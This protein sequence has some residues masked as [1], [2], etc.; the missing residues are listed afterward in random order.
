MSDFGV[1]NGKHSS[2]WRG[3]EDSEKYML[4]HSAS[5]GCLSCVKKF[6]LGKKIS[7]FSE[8]DH[9]KDNAFD[10]CEYGLEQGD[11][12]SIEAGAVMEFLN[13]HSKVESETFQG[14]IEAE[15]DQARIEPEMLC[16]ACEGSHARK[17]A[18][19]RGPEY[20]YFYAA[21]DGCVP[22]V[23]RI[24]SE[25]KI[26]V[27]S[28]SLTCGYDAIEWAVYGRDHGCGRRG[29]DH[30]AVLELVQEAMGSDGYIFA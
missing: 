18:L 27:F 26:D 19:M 8:S 25:G 4:F 24:V 6:V 12:S 13:E 1:C 29:K 30:G 21:R 28:K 16:V 17:Q 10:W 9:R 22:C 2:P 14:K 7:V 3:Y 23:K 11:A 5:V 15:T 20:E